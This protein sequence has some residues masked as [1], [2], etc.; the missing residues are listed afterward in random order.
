MSP[1]DD[2]LQFRALAAAVPA[3]A[4]VIL[5]VSALG[6]PAQHSGRVPY[7]ALAAGLC[8]LLAALA[9]AWWA[10]ARARAKRGRR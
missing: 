8:A 10:Q 3:L 1:Q 7:V 6:M 5:A 4:A 2:L 9:A